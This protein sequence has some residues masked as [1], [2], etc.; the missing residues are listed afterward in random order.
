[1]RLVTAWTLTVAGQGTLVQTFFG[2]MAEAE[3]WAT[4]VVGDSPYRLVGADG[5]VS[6]V[7][8]PVANVAGNVEHRRSRDPY[9]DVDP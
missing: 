1:M 6:E 8:P 4:M 2:D 7:V 9:N 5:Q 3:M